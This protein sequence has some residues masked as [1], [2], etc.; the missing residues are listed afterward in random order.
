MYINSIYWYL[1]G[2]LILFLLILSLVYFWIMR[3]S[4][5]F[6]TEAMDAVCLRGETVDAAL[7]IVNSSVLICPKAR[8][9]LSV[10]G[11]FGEDDSVSTMTFA[12]YGK[13]E[14]EFPF[15]MKMDHIGVYTYGIRE[16][17]IY[18]PLGIFR[19]AV[20]GGGTFRVTVLPRIFV[21][22]EI[23]LRERQLTESWNMS[24]RAVSDG[25]DYTGV[26]EYAMGDP[27][28]R[29]HWKLSA[30]S[31]A[32]MTRITE[33]SKKNDLTVVMDFVAGN[34]DRE[35]LPDIYDCL[36]ETA[37]SLVEQ[38]L[39]KDVEY[40]LLF[41]GH[42]REI[43]RAIPKGEQDYQELVPRLPGFYTEAGPDL[44]DGAEILNMESRLGNKG[45]NL[46]LCTSRI[47]EELIQELI[48]VK[49]QQRNPELYYIAPPNFH[50]G[51]AE[52]E[53]ASLEFLED[54]G[55]RYH[56]VTAGDER[57]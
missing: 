49:Q 55:V 23:R 45:S 35:V 2:L 30:H 3:R 10:S 11:F 20:K 17:K 25:F 33:S 40:S 44:P 7:K 4:M 46:F 18:E 22:E 56:I 29:I 47:T 39:T 27:M 53:M 42:D 16:M 32:Y 28:K 50:E 26:R 12:M 48:A 8:A 52:T 34:L 14:T 54:S 9:F 37:L 6:E 24:K 13:S 51:G 5:R 38:A 31:L 43:E 21:T 57:Q 41:V 19:I 15:H 36:V 1:P